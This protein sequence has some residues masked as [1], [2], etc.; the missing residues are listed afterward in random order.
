MA[1]NWF[2]NKTQLGPSPAIS[3]YTP[4]EPIGNIEYTPHLAVD[5]LTGFINTT[6]Y[7][8]TTQSPDLHDTSVD[9]IPDLNVDLWVPEK[10]KKI[11]IRASKHLRALDLPGG[12]YSIADIKRADRGRGLKETHPDTMGGNADRFEQRRGHIDALVTLIVKE[13]ISVARTDTVLNVNKIVSDITEAMESP[14]PSV[15][16]IIRLLTQLVITLT[17]F[18]IRFSRTEYNVNPITLDGPRKLPDVWPADPTER[19]K[20]LVEHLHTMWIPRVLVQSSEDIS[21]QRAAEAAQ[22]RDKLEEVVSAFETLFRSV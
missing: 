6:I 8:D 20:R 7:T 17:E 9:N 22:R 11:L 12:E 4:A 18:E 1:L 13:Q 14:T 2:H 3:V 15:S 21:I 19:I 10:D 5:D 16:E